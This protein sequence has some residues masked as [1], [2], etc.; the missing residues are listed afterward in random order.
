MT[1]RPAPS[2]DWHP[3]GTLAHDLAVL[4]EACREVR[5]Q[6]AI[7]FRRDMEAIAHAWRRVIEGVT[8]G[9]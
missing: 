3:P 5:R 9:A 1:D 8:N 7:A 4:T 2:C 6:A